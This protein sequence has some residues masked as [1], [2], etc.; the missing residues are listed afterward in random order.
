M[1]TARPFKPTADQLAAAVAHELES[2]AKYL[3]TVVEADERIA[4]ARVDGDEQ[5]IENMAKR[6]GTA[7]GALQVAAT[8]VT[9]Q[10]RLLKESK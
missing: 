4:L 3:R 1:A 8:N 9:Y 6:I 2:L 5:R 10:A 7:L